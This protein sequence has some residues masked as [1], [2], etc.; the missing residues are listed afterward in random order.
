MKLAPDREGSSPGRVARPG[1]NAAGCSLWGTL[2]KRLFRLDV[3]GWSKS[4]SDPSE[5]R[6]WE[7]VW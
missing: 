2:L 4:G 1:T 3:L 7:E 6:W 5:K